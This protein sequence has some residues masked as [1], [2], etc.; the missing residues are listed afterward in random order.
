MLD[1]D[2]EVDGPVQLP[3]A[4]RQEQQPAVPAEQIQ[5]VSQGAISREAIQGREP[6]SLSQ[7]DPLG[8]EEPAAVLEDL[9]FR[10][11]ESVE[12]DDGL[13]LTCEFSVKDL[14]ARLSF[15]GNVT[16]WIHR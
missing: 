12:L 14:R 3:G 15:A 7:P 11:V 1:E 2:E 16:S 6:P 8:G 13:V 10:E 5:D 9:G 4:Q